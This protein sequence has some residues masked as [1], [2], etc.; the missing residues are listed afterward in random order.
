MILAFLCPS[1]RKY[2]LTDSFE[3][4]F[5]KEYKKLAAS[6][7]NIR[8]NFNDS[9]FILRFQPILYNRDNP[10]RSDT[11][12]IIKPRN[13]K[14]LYTQ[15]IIPTIAA[16]NGTYYIPYSD[17]QLHGELPRRLILRQDIKEWNSLT[18][19]GSIGQRKTIGTLLGITRRLLLIDLESLYQS[20]S[21][22]IDMMYYVLLNIIPNLYKL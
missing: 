8:N 9:I 7:P 22:L 5:I 6:I 20:R 13:T 16:K 18:S 4:P 12:R 3:Y 17:I 11:I 19:Y 1:P 14:I 21:F 15:Y 2:G 10:A